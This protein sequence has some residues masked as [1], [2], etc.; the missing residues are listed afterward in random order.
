MTTEVKAQTIAKQAMKNHEHYSGYKQRTAKKSRSEVQQSKM[1]KKMEKYAC[2]VAQREMKTNLDN[3]ALRN[4]IVEDMGKMYDGHWNCLVIVGN[5]NDT[6]S[7][8]RAE[9]PT[10]HYKHEERCVTIWRSL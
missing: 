9:T 8:S 6:C 2:S 3:L 10:F 7:F 5:K 1:A 4:Q